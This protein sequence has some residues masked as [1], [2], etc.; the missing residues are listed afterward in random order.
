MYW[1]LAVI[2]IRPFDT[3]VTSF[4]CGMGLAVGGSPTLALEKMSSG[5]SAVLRLAECAETLENFDVHF[6]LTTTGRFHH[7]TD[8]TRNPTH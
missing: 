2:A 4:R 6:R 3:E 1:N 8:K 5:M 7:C